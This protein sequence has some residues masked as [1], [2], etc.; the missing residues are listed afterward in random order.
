MMHGDHGF[1][2]IIIT[3]REYITSTHCIGRHRSN[4][5]LSSCHMSFRSL[6]GEVGK[7]AMWD[8]I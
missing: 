4:K 5:E 3:V 6:G 1:A 2:L 8:Y 7:F